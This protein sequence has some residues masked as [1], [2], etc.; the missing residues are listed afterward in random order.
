M[1]DTQRQ[2]AAIR[3]TSSGNLLQDYTVTVPTGVSGYWIVINATTVAVSG[4]F[5]IVMKSADSATTC[6]IP[7]GAVQ[8]VYVSPTTGAVFANTPAAVNSVDGQIIYNEGGALVGSTGLTYQTASG[9]TV[10]RTDVAAATATVVS[11]LARKTSGTPAIGIGAQQGFDVQTQVGMVKAML[12]SSVAT[13]IS[14]GAETFDFTVAL[15]NAGVAAAVKFRVTGAGDV[16]GTTVS[17]GWVASLAEAQARTLNTAIMTPLRT[18]DAI[19]SRFAVTGTAP[20]FACRARG[21]FD[22]FAGVSITGTSNVATI[23]RQSL[24]RYTV[25]FTTALPNNTY[26]VVVTAGPNSGASAAL[27]GWAYGRTTTQFQIGVSDNN[28]DAPFDGYV[29]FM[30]IG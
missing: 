3:F 23:T 25:T 5:G 9:M 17:G 7:A 12:L 27:V 20:V 16:Q 11:N 4:T 29:D 28:S 6:E 14:S 18:D 2:S 30:V 10:D 15:R 24:G 1:T 19:T 21:T 8:T 26:T 22:G 13:N